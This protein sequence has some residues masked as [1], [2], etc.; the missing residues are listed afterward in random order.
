[1]WEALLAIRHNGC[2]V[3]DTSA[4]NPDVHLQNLARSQVSDGHAK[5]LLCLRGQP[6]HIDRF[7]VEFRDHDIVEKFERVSEGDSRGEYFSCEITYEDENPSLLQIVNTSGCYQHSTISVKNGVEN[8][9]VYTEEKSRIH[10]LISTI[11][12]LDNDIELY[13][14]TNIGKLNSDTAMEFT[15]LLSNLTSRQQTAFETALSLGYYENES[16]T[17]MEDIAD[18]LELHPSTAWEHVKKAENKLF[19]EIGQRLFTPTDD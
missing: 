11:E 17:T 1:M 12:T 2:P 9:I 18:V 7:A 19:T 6:D 16:D 4:R 14:S 10:E 15:A 13:R 8:W 5:R 3:S